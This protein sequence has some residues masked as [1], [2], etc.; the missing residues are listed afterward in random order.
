[1]KKGILLLL[2]MMMAAP[3]FAQNRTLIRRQ[4]QLNAPRQVQNPAPSQEIPAAAAGD[5][6][7]R[8]AWHDEGELVG[9]QFH[10]GFMVAPVLKLT[11][12][13]EHFGA[14][15]GG[16]AGWILNHTYIFGVGGYGTVN[17]IEGEEV[18]PGV[19]PKLSLKYGGAEFEYVFNPQEIVHFSAYLLVGVGQVEYDYHTD[20]K[21]D[22]TFFV[23]EPAGNIWVNVTDFFRAGLGI[24]Y[25][26]AAGVGLEG[27]ESGDVGGFT[28]TLTFAFGD[29]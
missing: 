21:G 23:V 16:R 28:G 7:P 2:L 14:L 4:N 18:R 24:G 15:I 27:I 10:H 25:R 26:F 3:V 29:F 6:I 9:G 5:M 12:V 19:K 8:E 13:N 11:Q 1:M 22:D 20:F 17:D